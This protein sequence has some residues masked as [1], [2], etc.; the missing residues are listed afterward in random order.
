MHIF[1]LWTENSFNECFTEYLVNLSIIR[2]RVNNL[3]LLS[4]R[5]ILSAYSE[6]GIDV[7]EASGW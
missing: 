4:E 5:L 7:T 6:A 2:F 3:S 1:S